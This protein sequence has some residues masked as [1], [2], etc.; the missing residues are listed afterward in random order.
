MAP[1]KKF[2][3]KRSFNLS[4]FFQMR[5]NAWLVYWLPLSL[6]RRYIAFIGRLYYA[7]HRQEK[8]LIRRTISH[9]C[10]Q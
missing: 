1:Q 3:W 6:S 9:V 2:R 8:E 7:V 5:L 10:K 4:M